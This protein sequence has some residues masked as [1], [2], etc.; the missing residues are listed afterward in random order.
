MFMLKNVILCDTINC[1]VWKNETTRHNFDVMLR[2]LRKLI[3]MKTSKAAKKAI[4]FSP[5]IVP[6][7]EE[8]IH[9]KP[10]LN[11]H[12]RVQWH[13]VWWLTLSH[14]ERSPQPKWRESANS[15]WVN[16]ILS[17]MKKDIFPLWS[18]WWNISEIHLHQ[19]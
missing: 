15:I 1:L 13:H 4:I 7:R 5:T 14:W 16:Y 12:P 2:R 11:F 8:K 17:K 3:F 9:I 10:A 6:Y 18:M 19:V